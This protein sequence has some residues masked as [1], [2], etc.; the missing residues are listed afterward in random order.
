MDHDERV[1]TTAC[2]PPNCP[3]ATRSLPSAITTIG[4]EIVFGSRSSG[5]RY[6]YCI[7]AGN[8]AHKA[9]R[10]LD[11]NPRAEMFARP[12]R[13]GRHNPT[14]RRYIDARRFY[15]RDVRYS[16]SRRQSRLFVISAAGPSVNTEQVVPERFVL[17][18]FR[19]ENMLVSPTSN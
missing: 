19:T 16:F 12:Y 8:R 4:I 14:K 1:P 11:W 6:G 10:V 7:G 5:E 17:R 3:A 18:A 13:I 9:R 15:R 2:T